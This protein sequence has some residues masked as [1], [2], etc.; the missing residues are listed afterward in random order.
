MKGVLVVGSVRD[1]KDLSGI[2]STVA[3]IINIDSVDSLLLSHSEIRYIDEIRDL[4]YEKIYYPENR[5]LETPDEISSAIEFL[6]RSVDYKFII[7]YSSKILKEA[8]AIASQRLYRPLITDVISVESEGESMI[9]TRNIMA[10]RVRSR[11]KVLDKAMILVGVGRS[12]PS[13]ISDKKTLIETIKV[14][15]ERS[16]NILERKPKAAATVRLEEAEIIVSVGRGFKSKED[17]KLAFELAEL[18]GGQIGCSRPI[19]AD[20]KWLP[21][22]HWVGLSGK[23]V[24]PKLYIALGI[25]GQP[26]HIAGILD[27][28]IIVAVN[29][30]PSAPIFKNADYGIVGDLYEFIPV[31][32]EAVK[33]LYSG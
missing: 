27:S 31:F 14:D 24:R 29:K 8:F 19:A 32:K 1:I 21:E 3:K 4:G 10:G 9:L 17:L 11:E 15:I 28:R 12:K 26:Q 22:E 30:D 16:L 5:T 23:K 20:L 7:G 13:K 2:A 18:L 25:S 33:K 6:T